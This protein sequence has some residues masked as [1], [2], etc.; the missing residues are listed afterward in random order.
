MNQK[1][2]EGSFSLRGFAKDVWDNLW[3]VAVAGLIAY[4]GLTGISGLTENPLYE[5]KATLVISSKE[6][7]SSITSLQTASQMAAVFSEV[8]RSESLQEKIMQDVGEKMEGTI[9]CRQVEET[10]LLALTAVS[11][12]PRHAY[13]M[14]RSA[15]ENYGEVSGYVFGQANLL[16]LTP[17]DVPTEPMERET[18]LSY[19]KY[20]IP[21]AML[22]M[23][24][25]IG[26]LYLFRFTIKTTKG[27]RRQLE[28]N[29]LG[30]IPYEKPSSN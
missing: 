10:N 1:I 16:V 24:F 18:L 13:L 15:I 7:Y 5:S 23:V 9:S 22:L 11:D 25:V 28:G 17:P 4:L 6:S 14:L 19:R 29:V 27:A 30:T 20:L 26:I 2:T 3:M 8:F 12:N 21:A